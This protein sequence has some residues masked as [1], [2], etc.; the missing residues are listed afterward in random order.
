[1]GRTL[2]IVSSRK[3]GTS[4][5]MSSR[6]GRTSSISHPRPACCSIKALRSSTLITQSLHL[7][8]SWNWGWLKIIHSRRSHVKLHQTSSPMTLRNLFRNIPLKRNLCQDRN[9]IRPWTSIIRPITPLSTIHS[10]TGIS[11][12]SWMRGRSKSLS[13]GSR[14]SNPRYPTRR[15]P[16]NPQCSPTHL[17]NT[18]KKRD[19]PKSHILTWVRRSL[20]PRPSSASSTV[21]SQTRWWRVE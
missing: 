13:T 10:S 2:R 11:Q 3:A 4:S 20:C 14:S 19:F 16:S 9:T 1:M 12:P 18:A 21:S 15:R 6:A 7:G 5:A 17:W 8:M